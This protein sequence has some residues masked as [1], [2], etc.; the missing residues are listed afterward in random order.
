MQ[1]KDE[2]YKGMEAYLARLRVTDDSIENLLKHLHT[3]LPRLEGL[4]V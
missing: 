3:R 2:I 1:L 4:L